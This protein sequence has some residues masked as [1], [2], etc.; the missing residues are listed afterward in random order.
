MPT[1]SSNPN[2]N[3]LVTKGEGGAY[4]RAHLPA[5]NSQ[6]RVFM[7]ETG[8]EITAKIRGLLRTG[9][10]NK[11]V[12]GKLVLLQ[13]DE[14]TTREK[15]FIVYI[16]SDNEIKQLRKLGEIV[17][18]KEKEVSNV[19]FVDDS[20][21]NAASNEESDGDDEDFVNGI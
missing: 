7:T 17:D 10:N 2:T 19:V 15:W 4:A 20:V 16:Y 21:P 12:S 18:V 11:V 1:K 9:K 8:Q 3:T 13:R 6:F 5:G 14:S